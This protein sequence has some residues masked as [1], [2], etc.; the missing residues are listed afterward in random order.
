MVEARAAAVG[1]LAKTSD[2]PD[3]DVRVL[4]KHAL[5]LDDAGLIAA[6]D[7][8][9]NDDERRRFEALI[10]RRTRC[11]PVAY[12]IGRAEFWSLPVSVGPETLI[13][14]PETERLVELALAARPE[15]NAQV[16]DFGTG[17]GA[18]LCALLSQRPGWRG[19]GV[20]RSEPAARRARAN[21][22][23]LGLSNRASIVVG[24]WGDAVTAEFDLIVANPPYVRAGAALPAS[25]SAFEPP[26]A[27]FAGPD[28]LDDLRAI[29]ADLDR[30]VAP[31]GCAL[32]E[33]GADQGAAASELA[34]Q[35]T[36]APDVAVL[37]D[38]AGLD[39]V[40]RLSGLPGKVGRPNA[41]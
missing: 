27:L 25:V 23:A 17:S 26:E 14:R 10:D 7:R 22:S 9:L 12:I 40:L 32:F 15:P 4:M 37:T 24:S 36:G 38:L 1:R 2:T 21:L 18:I 11:E 35:M 30:I 29:L 20:D 3:L 8:L 16:I 5:G 34:E 13:P 19:L 6:S 33:I 41:K 28:G 31:G 39:R